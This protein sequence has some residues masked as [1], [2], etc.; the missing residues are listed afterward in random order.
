MVRESA[1]PRASGPGVLSYWHVEQ[2]SLAIHSQL[3]NYTSSEVA[4]MIDGAMRAGHHDG[5]RGHLHGCAWPCCYM[6]AYSPMRRTCAAMARVQRSGT[7]AQNARPDQGH[8]HA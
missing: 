3:I 7:H 4:A 5:Y 8:A 1:N 2:K 6:D